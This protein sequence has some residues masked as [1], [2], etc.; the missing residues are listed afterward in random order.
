MTK[1]HPHN[2]TIVGVSAVCRYPK[3]HIVS[4]WNRS[5]QAS[6]STESLARPKDWDRGRVRHAPLLSLILNKDL[7][8]DTR[9]CM[10]RFGVPSVRILCFSGVIRSNAHAGQPS[11]QPRH[12]WAEKQVGWLAGLQSPAC[13]SYSSIRGLVNQ[14]HG[15]CVVPLSA[16]N[17]ECPAI[18]FPNL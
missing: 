7:L 1:V 10:S 9:T 16:G 15:P 12:G 11:F 8:T 4:G 2:N 3:G 13:G 6:D 5:M 14:G 17:V 18:P